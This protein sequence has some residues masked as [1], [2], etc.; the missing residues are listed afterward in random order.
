MSDPK[1][2]SAD[3]SMEEI[4]ATIRKIIAEDER[5]ATTPV[6]RR[7]SPQDVLVLTEAVAE[8]GSLRHVPARAEAAAPLPP[9]P[10]GRREPDPPSPEP[11][12]PEP[13]SPE[14]LRAEPLS[15]EP[16]A[17]EPLSPELRMAE[18]PRVE[19]LVSGTAEDGPALPLPRLSTA[20]REGADGGLR[21]VGADKTLEDIVR[22]MLR[23]MLQSWL[24]D[25]LPPLVE[26]LVRAEIA[27]AVGDAKPR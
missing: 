12:S 7:R 16:P 8:D 26:R 4:L 10:D 1:P 9:L 17:R 14:P 5:A 21:L 25:R 6:S 23:P 13:L 3:P 20:S 18:A 27:R 22:E 11:L 24:D 2:S 19:P 15:P